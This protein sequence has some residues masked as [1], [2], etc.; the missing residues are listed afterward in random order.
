MIGIA[1]TGKLCYPHSPADEDTARQET[2]RLTDSDWMF[3]HAIVLDAVCLGRAEP[4]AGALRKL[5]SEVTPE[6]WDTMHAVPDFIGVNSY[7]GS[8]IAAG[9]DG[10][11]L[12]AAAV[13]L[14]LHGAQVAHHAGNY[15][16]RLCV[17]L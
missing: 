13:G 10:A 9:P 8:E 17:P 12:S 11:G 7:N 5:L 4:E 16:V 15:G 1:S 14:C 2:F 6:E 3:T